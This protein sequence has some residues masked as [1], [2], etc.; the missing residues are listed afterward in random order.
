MSTL[1]LKTHSQLTQTP[2]T[3]L[4][5]CLNVQS[6]FICKRNLMYNFYVRVL[7]YTWDTFLRIT[8]LKKM[9]RNIKILQNI[10]ISYQVQVL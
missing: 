2:F 10:F 6:C 4:I 9:L 1:K 8:I 3:A 7:F 5:A